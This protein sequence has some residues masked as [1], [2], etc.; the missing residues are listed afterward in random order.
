[1]KKKI[2]LGSV[3]A[4]LVAAI[5]VGIFLFRNKKET[6]DTGIQR[7]V[8][9]VYFYDAKDNPIPLKEKMDLEPGSR[10]TTGD[11][12]LVTLILDKTKIF[13]L[14]ANSNARIEG[15]SK[16]L[17]IVMSEGSFYFNVTE[18][19]AKDETFDV[20][21][22]NI[23][24]KVRGTS[25]YGGK[26]AAGHSV[27]AVT[28]G[29]GY[30]E[31]RNEATGEETSCIVDSGDMITIYL[32]DESEGATLLSVTTAQL[33]EEDLPAMVLDAI[34][35]D[36]ELQERIAEATGLSIE[37]IIALAEAT[38]HEGKSM[39]GEAEETFKAQG[40]SDAI[41][42]MGQEARDMVDTAN[43][44]ADI[45]EE[46][47]N[48]EIAII[49]GIM[50]VLET[51]KDNGVK[52][53]ELAA[54]I[55]K[56]TECVCKTVKGAK[57]LGV[58]GDDLIKISRSVSDTLTVS[59]D[60]MEV[61][62]LSSKEID[63]VVDSVT[64]VYSGMMDV[65]G[66]GGTDLSSAVYDAVRNAS[67]IIKDTISAE[68][69]ANAT[70][71]ETVEALLGF[72]DDSQDD[73]N[74]TV[75]HV[76]KDNDDKPDN[77]DDNETDNPDEGE[78]KT[79]FA[80]QFNI[81]NGCGKAYAS[82]GETAVEQA[83]QGDSVTINCNPDYGYYLKELSAKTSGENGIDVNRQGT[84]G[85]FSMPDGEVTVTVVFVPVEYTVTL[86]TDGG[87]IRQG[88]VK[89]YSY[90]IGAALPTAVT[91]EATAEISYTFDGWYTE[92]SG[93]RKIT[94]IG[95]TA[96]G[97]KTYY[98]HWTESPRVYA[99]TIITSGEGKAIATVDGNPVSKAA[100]GDT[101]TITATPADDYEFVMWND[102]AGN[103]TTSSLD[104]VSVTFSMPAGKVSLEA[105]F[106]AIKRD[107]TIENAEH[108]T[109]IPDKSR[110]ATGDTITLTVSPNNGYQLDS[111]TIT[112][113][114]GEV[115]VSG[116]DNIRTFT[117]PR[118]EVTVKATFKGIAY[119]VTLDTDGG[120]IA[121]GNVTSYVCGIGA[122]LPTDL[123]KEDTEEATFTFDGWY[124]MKE[125]GEKVT[126]IGTSET[127]D[128]TYY[129]RFTASPK[130]SAITED[131]KLYFSGLAAGGEV[132]VIACLESD[133]SSIADG[134]EVKPGTE[135][136]L[137]LARKQSDYMLSDLYL[138]DE[139]GESADVGIEWNF[140]DE[141]PE[142]EGVAGEGY[143]NG[144]YLVSF[145]MPSADV[146][147]GVVRAY[148][149]RIYG[150]GADLLDEVPVE[151][152][153]LTYYLTAGA[154][155]YLRAEENDITLTGVYRVGDEF[156]TI[157][158]RYDSESGRYAFSMPAY[159][160][161]IEV[162]AEAGYIG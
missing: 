82:V 130:A 23:V 1:M 144:Y 39:Y 160:V 85:S 161:N 106:T 35:K 155:Y 14:E 91:K 110:A 2:I 145:D 90:G 154:E 63:A 80:I 59:I 159:P 143:V 57:D 121:S 36:K 15:T 43:E 50:D 75:T 114:S 77:P 109:I 30:L 56:S 88:D 69:A 124:T 60:K 13:T 18:K 133:G 44:A 138:T 5:A 86:V 162:T 64:M 34:R 149:L 139:N 95:A 81:V 158:F 104:E 117:M 70:G 58:K 102:E 100:V 49:E 27:F 152:A 33:K 42:I 9:T 32:D 55:R 79:G 11:D 37:K 120:T 126:A 47:L 128:K 7:L 96:T 118:E 137:I 156:K 24:M 93:G 103:L 153:P 12:S 3:G 115:F 62:K 122:I 74:D 53:E 19:L 76:E 71:D 108:G 141:S 135:V 83:K 46:D 48:L 17:E 61:A 16:N 136:K 72:K 73:P 68:M 41:P 148:L 78:K 127:G 99:I 125:G 65:A 111:I 22:G 21:I 97:N 54:L 28:D 123:M 132:S 66:K 40:T 157:D 51:G 4:L 67:K 84:T 87:E 134:D 25:V 150:D 45:A 151:E 140:I 29:T 98:A 89:V 116:L 6:V 52:K 8:G 107:I 131:P 92:Q 119:T 113:K 105:V 142:S 146:T 129:A 101:V 31:S 10:I 26:D 94:V 38:S 112:G 20:R 147:V